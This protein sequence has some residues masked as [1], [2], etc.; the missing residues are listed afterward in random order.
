MSSLFVLLGN[1]EPAYRGYNRSYSSYRDYKQIIDSNARNEFW[2][3]MNASTNLCLEKIAYFVLYKQQKPTAD[4]LFKYNLIIFSV[5]LTV[6]MTR[7]LV[8]YSFWSVCLPFNYYFAVANVYIKVFSNSQQG[9]FSVSLVSL[10]IH[11]KHQFQV[12]RFN[13]KQ[14]YM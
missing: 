4:P 13:L 3:N 10:H 5:A 8:F 7:K 2:A 14:N 11:R 9:C 12:L 1:S 6:M